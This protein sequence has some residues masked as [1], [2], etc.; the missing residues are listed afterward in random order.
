[1]RPIAIFVMVR[2]PNGARTRRVNPTTMFPHPMTAPNPTSTNP[3]Q[4][5]TGGDRDR[6]HKRRRGRSRD[7]DFLAHRGRRRRLPIN[8]SLANHTTAYQQR[9]DGD[10]K[11]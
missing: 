4:T 6:F 9:T 10:Q 7:Y 3:N 11:S 1:M 2:H 5:R 8:H